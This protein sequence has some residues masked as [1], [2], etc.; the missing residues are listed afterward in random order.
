VAML[1]GLLVDRF[2]LRYQLVTRELPVY[3][4]V[5]AKGGV[6][7]QTKEGSC[8][9]AGTV[10]AQGQR[11]PGVCGTYFWRGGQVD[12]FRITMSQLVVALDS[13]LDRPLIDKTG[14]S[15]AWDIHLAWNPD[16]DAGPSIYT[17]LQEQLGLKL[18]AAK[19]PA[20]VLVIDHIERPG[21][22]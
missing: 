16:D 4:L 9:A 19:A 14:L 13:Q 22:N 8:V 1:Q 18:E 7:L 12:G 2:K 10:E 15:G 6:K 20:Q 21:E 17:A 5:A 11:P 3:A